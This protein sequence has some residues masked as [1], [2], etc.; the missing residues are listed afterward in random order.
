MIVVN[1]S[2]D[3]AGL[4]DLADESGHDPANWA[5][6]GQALGFA[7]AA[8][9]LRLAD[10]AEIAWQPVDAVLGSRTVSNLFVWGP[11]VVVHVVIVRHDGPVRASGRR[12]GPGRAGRFP[13]WRDQDRLLVAGSQASRAQGQARQKPRPIQASAVRIG[14]VYRRNPCRVTASAGRVP[15][16]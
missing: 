8:V 6:V 3:H 1:F 15:A 12:P 11:V 4:R 13:L 10:T 9:R 14:S 5:K 2:W 7:A 16:A